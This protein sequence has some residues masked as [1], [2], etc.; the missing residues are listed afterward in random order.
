[1]VLRIIQF[2]F[3][4]TVCIVSPKEKANLILIP[5]FLHSIPITG[6]IV[7]GVNQNFIYDILRETNISSI[8]ISF[9]LLESATQ[10]IESQ[11]THHID[12]NNNMQQKMVELMNGLRVVSEKDEEIARLTKERSQALRKVEEYCNHILETTA[13]WEQ[14]SCALAKSSIDRLEKIATQSIA[15]VSTSLMSQKFSEN[16]IYFVFLRNSIY[17]Y[18]NKRKLFL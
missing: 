18:I 9:Q 10:S 12:N 3:I 2:Y 8:F 15:E 5:S 14:S 17:L 6:I 13:N 7:F 4:V 16:I 11:N 1:M